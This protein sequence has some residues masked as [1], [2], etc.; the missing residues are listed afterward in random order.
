M[1]R[2][3]W[4]DAKGLLQEG[5]ELQVLPFTS[6]VAPIGS[7]LPECGSRHI[8]CLNREISR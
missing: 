4:R 8:R 7:G 6:H 5:N 3:P 2:D 1:K